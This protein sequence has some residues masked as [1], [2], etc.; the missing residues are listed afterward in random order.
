MH[1]LLVLLFILATSLQAVPASAAIYATYACTNEPGGCGADSVPTS[2]YI[3]DKVDIYTGQEFDRI[4]TAIPETSTFPMIYVNS[5]GGSVA[6][7]IRIARV[8]RARAGKIEG[9]DI[10][11]PDH[12]HICSSAC[13]LLSAGGV[14]RNLTNIGLHRM[15]KSTRIKGE[16]YEHSPISDEAEAFIADFYTEMGLPKELFQEEMKVPFDQLREINFEPDAPFD[17]QEIVRLGFRTRKPDLD[18]VGYLKAIDKNFTKSLIS[19][20]HAAALGNAQAAFEVGYRYFEGLNG[21]AISVERGLY[22][23]NRAS[24]MNHLRAMHFLGVTYTNGY[25]GIK[26][27][28]GLALE[29]LRKAAKLGFASSQNNLGWHYYAA[30]GVEKNL[31]EAIYWITRSVDQG[32]PFAYDSL[33]EILLDGNGFVQDDIETYKWTKL[34]QKFLPKGMTKENNAKRLATLNERMTE[35]QIKEADVLVE[36]WRPLR[37]TTSV[38]RDKEDD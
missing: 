25:Q 3:Y 22:W 28:Q 9:K 27:D 5:S 34:G 15:H 18:E 4:S 32:E 1:K 10:F 30:I 37:Q 36:S 29:Y 6:S 24:E 17:D 7:A 20:E 35:G 13:V 31:S 23:L 14:E 21:E 19:L 12:K 8:L 38:M 33:G 11:F 16:L 26:I 2:L